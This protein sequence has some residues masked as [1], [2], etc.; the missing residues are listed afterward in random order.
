MDKSQQVKGLDRVQDRIGTDDKGKRKKIGKNN[1]H[2]SKFMTTSKIYFW[3]TLES[4][5]H[6]ISAPIAYIKHHAH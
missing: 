1:R 2:R 5:M 4:G 6:Y 3:N